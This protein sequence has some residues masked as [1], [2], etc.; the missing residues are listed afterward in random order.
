MGL[1]TTTS[2]LQTL[3]LAAAAPIGISGRAQ[4]FPCVPHP[5]RAKVKP[6]GD[7]RATLPPSGEYP[8]EFVKCVAEVA[9]KLF[10]GHPAREKL[11]MQA[12]PARGSTDLARGSG[13]S[14]QVISS[15]SDEEPRCA[16]REPAHP[17]V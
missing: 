4:R 13:C 17:M 14:E 11:P 16:Q 15:G 5:A 8:P 1:G 2:P 3:F 10:L 9:R 12:E 6:S 7:V